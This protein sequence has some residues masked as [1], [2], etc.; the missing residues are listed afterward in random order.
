MRAGIQWI[1]S[2]ALV[3]EINRNPRRERRIESA[4]LLA[5]A[6]ET[7]GLNDHIVDRAKQLQAAGYGPFDAL[8]LACAEAGRA[9]ILL[10][11]ALRGNGSLLISVRNPLSWSQEELP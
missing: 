7:V 9:D 5:H 3:E 4:A 2:E 8:H 10:R 1:S 6:T 11:K